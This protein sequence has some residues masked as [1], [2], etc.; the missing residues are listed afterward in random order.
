MIMI[1]EIV[2]MCLF[3]VVMFNNTLNTLRI[4]NLKKLT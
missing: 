2:K 1:I 3:W 4:N